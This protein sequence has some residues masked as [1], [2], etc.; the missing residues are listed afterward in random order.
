MAMWNVPRGKKV[1]NV[2]LA[3]L[4]ASLAFGLVILLHTA[5]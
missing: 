2:T 5:L 4:L 3:L 1:A